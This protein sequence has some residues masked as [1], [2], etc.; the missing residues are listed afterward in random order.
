[1]INTIPTLLSFLDDI[2]PETAVRLASYLE[3]FAH[4]GCIVTKSRGRNLLAMTRL[5]D[6]KLAL[7]A[8]SEKIEEVRKYIKRFLRPTDNLCSIEEFAL[9]KLLGNWLND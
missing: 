9:F 5:L 2:L 4:N 6:M 3:S 1:R 7:V 8:F